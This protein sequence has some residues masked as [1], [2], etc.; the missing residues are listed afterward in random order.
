MAVREA[1]SLRRVPL[2]LQLGRWLPRGVRPSRLILT[3]AVAAFVLA[4]VLVQQTQGL[5]RAGGEIQRLELRLDELI[6]ESQELLAALVER[7]DL[8]TL[9]R[10]T[11]TELGM[12]PPDDPHYTQVRALPPG[13]S[14][15]LPLWAAPTAPLREPFWLELLLRALGET[16]NR[17]RE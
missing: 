2:A 8:P 6:D 17:F 15:D 1:P 11:Y 3:F 16:L 7:N 12:R 10:R 5:V 13:I 14:F 4:M 9:Q